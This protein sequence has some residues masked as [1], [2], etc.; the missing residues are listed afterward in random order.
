[1]EVLKLKYQGK[2][3]WNECDRKAQKGRRENETFRQFSFVTLV[4][5]R[6]KKIRSGNEMEQ[7]KFRSSDAVFMR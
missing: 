1:M 6:H 5:K 7:E 4:M 2:G 3:K